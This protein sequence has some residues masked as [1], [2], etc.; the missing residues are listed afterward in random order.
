MKLPNGG[1]IPLRIDNFCPHV[2]KKSLTDILGMVE[3][4]DK[5]RRKFLEKKNH[6]A[7]E[8]NM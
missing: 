6:L 3:I 8:L 5:A 4:Q 7:E 2:S 1:F